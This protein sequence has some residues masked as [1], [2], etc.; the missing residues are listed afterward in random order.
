MPMIIPMFLTKALIP[1][2]KPSFLGGTE[3]KTLLLLGD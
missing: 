1:P 2:A 3:L